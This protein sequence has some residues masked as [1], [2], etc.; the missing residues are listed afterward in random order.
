MAA[1]PE[2]IFIERLEIFRQEAC[3]CAQF[4]YEYLAIHGAAARDQD[5]RRALNQNAL[6]WNTALAALQTSTLIA[7]GRVFDQKGKHG[8]RAL[9]DLARKHAT[10]FSKAALSQRK[11][12]IFAND[13]QALEDYLSKSYEPGDAEFSRLE[14]LVQAATD[15]YNRAYRP[16]RNQV[17]AHKVHGEA[18][19]IEALFS[20]TN[21]SKLERLVTFLVRFHWALQEALINGARLTLRKTRYSVNEMLERPAG[22]ATVKPVQEATVIDSH[23]V[24]KTVAEAVSRELAAARQPARRRPPEHPAEKSD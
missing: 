3:Q 18:E 20:Q 10:I 9:L 19:K 22:P 11:A 23:A 4:L 17:F 14:R 6:F 16:L 2:Q 5:V 7:L 13:P 12:G 1:T 15:R 21:V 24:L 8:I